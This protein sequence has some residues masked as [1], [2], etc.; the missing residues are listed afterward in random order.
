MDCVI[1]AVK[2]T[3]VAHTDLTIREITAAYFPPGAVLAAAPAPAPAPPPPPSSLGKIAQAARSQGAAFSIED[4]VESAAAEGSGAESA[5]TVMA[6]MGPDKFRLVALDEEGT[7]RDP[8]VNAPNPPGAPAKNVTGCGPTT[9][10]G[11][12]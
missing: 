7:W 1:T 3:A 5:P 4:F 8:E 9:R 12:G 2:E 11:V 6:G 10:V